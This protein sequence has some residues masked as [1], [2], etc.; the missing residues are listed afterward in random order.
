MQKASNCFIAIFTSYS[1]YSTA[2]ELS[3]IHD[4]P[5]RQTDRQ[6][7]KQTDRQTDGRTMRNNLFAGRTSYIPSTS[8]QMILVYK[9]MTEQSRVT[10]SPNDLTDST[11]LYPPFPLRDLFLYYE[12]AH[13]DEHTDGRTDRQTVPKIV[14]F[15][16]QRFVKK[17][18]MTTQSASQ[19]YTDHP[20]KARGDLYLI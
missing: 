18:L 15:A 11:L 6:T 8:H 3:F 19:P 2:F 13:T 12:P 10:F 7:N 9:S 5:A 16:N 1:I 14:F 4:S 20:T 17:N